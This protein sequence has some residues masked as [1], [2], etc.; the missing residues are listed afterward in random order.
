VAVSPTL[1]SVGVLALIVLIR[2]FLSFSLETKM[3]RRAA[4]ASR[5]GYQR[6]GRAV[7]RRVQGART[8]AGKNGQTS[9]S[10][11]AQSTWREC[12]PAWSSGRTKVGVEVGVECGK[13]PGVGWSSAKAD[14]AVGPHEQGARFGSA[15]GS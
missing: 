4:L 2:T 11:I 9:S 6:R 10:V 14:V 5:D 1:E 15:G 7:P 13:S 3:I 12:R 8:D